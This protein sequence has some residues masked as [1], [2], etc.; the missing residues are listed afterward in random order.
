MAGSLSIRLGSITRRAV[1]TG[2]SSVMASFVLL[3]CHAPS[4]AGA[5]A[6]DVSK[7]V[8]SGETVPGTGG[9]VFYSV[10]TNGINDSGRV[11]VGGSYYSPSLLRGVF[12]YAG[13]MLTD[14]ALTGTVSPLSG[15]TFYSPLGGQINDVGDI[16]FGSTVL[17]SP[18][19]DTSGLFLRSG[20]VFSTLVLQG[21]TAPGTG[22]TFAN[23][24]V[25]S[26][27]NA[28]HLGFIGLYGSGS[29]PTTPQ[30]RGLFFLGGGSLTNLAL[31][32]DS[33]IGTG[34]TYGGFFNATLNNMDE[35][36]FRATINGGTADSGFFLHAGGTTIPVALQGQTAPD[37]GGTFGPFT[38]PRNTVS[39]NDAGEIVFISGILGGGSTSGIFTQSG[40]ATQ[41][42]VAT[43]EIAPGTGGSTFTAFEGDLGID[44]AGRIA[45]LAHISGGHPLGSGTDGV[46]VYDPQSGAIYAVALSGQLAPGTGGL[47]YSTFGSIRMSD[48]GQ[49]AF[50]AQLDNGSNGVFL[51]TPVPEPSSLVLLTLAGSTFLVWRRRREADAWKRKGLPDP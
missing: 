40:G 13:G 34:G 35:M 15:G 41:L 2:F 33:A 37:V 51:G 24:D 50:T 10:N 43:G 7:I 28:G 31:T 14:V 6:F 39:I 19:G 26:L 30:P 25:Y 49:I 47:A 17:G 48:L 20:G 8:L 4:P 21:D 18:S 16:A 46:F 1:I 9:E 29:F 12:E 22:T 5:T 23:F 42:A 3:D 36:V 27:N 38:G 45:F 32:G 11:A 44:D